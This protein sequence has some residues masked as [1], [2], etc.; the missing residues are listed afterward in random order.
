MITETK[1]DYP[2]PETLLPHRPPFLL[3][4]NIVDFKFGE[5]LTANKEIGKD[6]I[7]FQGH[8]PGYP[9]LPGV[10]LVEMM[11]QTC[12]LYGRLEALNFGNSEQVQVPQKPASGRAI[13]IKNVSFHKEI[14]PE[15][16][17]QIEVKF[18]HKLMGFSEFDA[19]VICEGKVA[20]K[21]SVTVHIS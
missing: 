1:I 8:F 13:K 12:G 16:K 5:S 10:I 20:A 3:V 17:L 11:F 2:K 19:K 14:R 18:K 15:S 6:E 21:G 4:D 7:F 9:L